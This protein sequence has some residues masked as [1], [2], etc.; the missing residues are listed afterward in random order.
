MELKFFTQE[1]YIYSPTYYSLLKGSRG[2]KDGN[3]PFVD[4]TADIVISD[5]IELDEDENE[6][7]KINVLVTNEKWKDPLKDEYGHT[8][9]VSFNFEM[10][11]NDA[12]YLHKYLEAFLKINSINR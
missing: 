6:I 1:A 8:E 12:V 7:P 11:I 3:Y 4:M 5:I 10:T 9:R 2:T